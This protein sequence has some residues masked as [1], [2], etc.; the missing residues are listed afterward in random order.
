MPHPQAAPMLGLKPNLRARS[1]RT[2]KSQRRHGRTTIRTCQT[3]S[4]RK[5]SEKAEKDAAK[6]KSDD[7]KDG[8]KSDTKAAPDKPA[9]KAAET[10]KPAAK[11][12]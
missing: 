9:K 8:K 12:D 10:K 11:K 7:K 3:S 5:K 2:G 6:P 1:A 4:P